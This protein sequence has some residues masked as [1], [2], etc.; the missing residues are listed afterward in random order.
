MSTKVRVYIEI[1]KGSNV[2][3]EYNK[4]TG[5]L[6]VDRVLPSQY[7][8]PYAYGFIPDTRAADGDDLDILLIEDEQHTIRNNAYYDAYIVG[9][10]RMEDEKG[11][12]EKVLCTLA[13]SDADLNPV[14]L[15]EIETYFS[16]Y[17]TLCPGKWSRTYGFMDKADAVALYE[18]SKLF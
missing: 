7:A 1:E 4:E 8:Y 15:T 11:M 18:A 10:L 17:K 2:K 3:Y 14:V 9:A 6:E 5:Q 13:N 16:T 12:D